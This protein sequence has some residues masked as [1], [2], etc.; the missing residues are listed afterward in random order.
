M[1]PAAS[2]PYTLSLHDALPISPGLIERPYVFAGNDLPGV[3][4]STAVRRLINL[5]DRKSTRLNSS[6]QI[7]SYA[8]FRL[9]KKSEF[10]PIDEARA[11]WEMAKNEIFRHSRVRD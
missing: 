5:Q 1:S 6:H 3:M 4:L 10:E 11:F 2:S 9:K 8:V 7:T